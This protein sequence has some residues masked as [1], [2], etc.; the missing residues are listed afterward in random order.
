MVAIAGRHGLAGPAEKEEKEERE[1]AMKWLYHKHGGDEAWYL[2][3]E[4]EYWYTERTGKAFKCHRRE[5]QLSRIQELSPSTQAAVTAA[6]QKAIDQ[7]MALLP[8]PL[9]PTALQARTCKC[10]CK[11]Q[12]RPKGEF[13]TDACRLRYFRQQQRKAKGPGQLDLPIAQ[14]KIA[15]QAFPRVVYDNHG[16]KVTVDEQR[17][18]YGS[19]T[20]EEGTDAPYIV[21]TNTELV[22]FGILKH[23]MNKVD[24]VRP[25]QKTLDALI[26]IREAFAANP[27][28]IHEFHRLHPA[29][30]K[31][32]D[33]IAA[34]RKV[35]DM[36]AATKPTFEE[37]YGKQAQQPAAGPKGTP[38]SERARFEKIVIDAMM[39][40][41]AVGRVYDYKINFLWGSEGY[42]F[43]N[44]YEKAWNNA[45]TRLQK[46][47]KILH[48]NDKS[49]YRHRLSDEVLA[50]H[51]PEPPV[52]APSKIAQSV[53]KRPV[54]PPAPKP[55]STEKAPTGKAIGLTKRI[56]QLLETGEHRIDYIVA[57]LGLGQ[58]KFNSV[59]STINLLFLNGHIGRRLVPSADTVYS[60]A[61]TSFYK[62]HNITFETS[63]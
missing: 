33:W 13:A 15:S 6:F 19:Y 14:E 21:N 30:Q 31:K 59:R 43:S 9:R 44:G 61:S 35:G 49:D 18:G 10:G 38:A 28:P 46:A 56:E 42:D 34:I 25:L 57:S 22:E 1:N 20:I 16:I 36:I 55:R 39:K 45:F 53:N 40:R 58:D 32:A 54:A 26:M 52:A 4:D 47:G 23:L 62:S 11:S 3:L 41:H 5:G 17:P 12:P 50:M 2:V 51:S 48:N 60:Y 63:K 37:R 27:L 8:E 7:W 29:L 24:Q